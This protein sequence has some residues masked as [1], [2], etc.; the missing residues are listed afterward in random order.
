M[1]IIRIILR[2]VHICS[3]TAWVGA[4]FFTA[5]FLQPTIRAAGADST[6]AGRTG[7]GVGVA[8]QG[9]AVN[10]CVQEDIVS[11]GSD[12]RRTAAPLIVILLGAVLGQ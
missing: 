2:I 1:E 6:D 10:V 11:W 7:G 9:K 5:L 3:G 12:G 8:S 4:A